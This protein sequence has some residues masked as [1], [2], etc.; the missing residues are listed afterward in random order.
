[1]ADTDTDTDTPP[2][3]ID[4]TQDIPPVR[5]LWGR[6]VDVCRSRWTA[7]AFLLVAFGI[8]VGVGTVADVSSTSDAKACVRSAHVLNVPTSG[9]APLWEEASRR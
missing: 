2:P 4:D 5:N 8:G 6:I 1:M 7:A 3:D 9:C